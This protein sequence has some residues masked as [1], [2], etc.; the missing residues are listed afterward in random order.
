MIAKKKNRPIIII[1]LT[2]G[3]S[4]ITFAI[5][6]A[7]NQDIYNKALTLKQA[8]NIS[9]QEANKWDERA[10]LYSITSA[11]IPEKKE[12]SYGTDGKRSFWNINYAIP[13]TNDHYIVSIQDGQV[14]EGTQTK[15]INKTE[16]LISSEEINFDSPEILSMAL[17]KFKIQTGTSW[18][19][20]YHFELSKN[21]KTPMIGIVGWDSEGNF[22]KI[23]YNAATGKLIDGYHKIPV[24][25][26]FYSNSKDILTVKGTPLNVIGADIYK[27]DSGN[28]IFMVWGY[29]NSSGSQFIKISQDNGSNWSDINLNN[30]AVKLWFSKTYSSDKK[31]FAFTDKNLLVTQ[32]NGV[33]WNCIF[34]TDSL[35][36][37]IADNK[38]QIAILT[39]KSLHLSYDGGRAWENFSIPPNI[40]LVAIDSN[41]SIYLSTN[42]EVYKKINGTYEKVNT[43][44]KDD[45]LGLTT[46]KNV[47][48]CYTATTIGLLKDTGK[49]DYTNIPEGIK[50]ITFSSNDSNSQ[51]Y[52]YCDNDILQRI[53]MGGDSNWATEIIQRP[54]EG[55]LNQLIAVSADELYFCMVS[56]LVWETL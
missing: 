32:D 15:G 24:G 53:Q 38:N 39:D 49:W 9:L 1:L 21:D 48:C 46:Y 20:G 27:E 22:T 41:N 23:F 42:R 37:D 7:G 8:Y 51:L 13:N 33:S 25:G 10:K 26:G 19:K 31:I 30:S 5:V 55:Q 52:I 12:K 2:L 44:L 40:L 50:S 35:I 29:N 4:I 54:M 47:L 45:I 6:N 36:Y 17:H 14:F 18:A 3:I 43:D 11:D 56:N 16:K 34:S 28:K